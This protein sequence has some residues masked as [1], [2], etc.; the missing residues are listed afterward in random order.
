MSLKLLIANK[1]YSSWSVRP[2]LVLDH[3]Q[4][5]YELVRGRLKSAHVTNE[6]AT[7]F[8][9]DWSRAGKVPVLRD[10]DLTVWESL[11][12]IEYLADRFPAKQIWPADAG[13]RALARAVS[14][15]MHAGFTPLRGEMPMNVRRRYE[16]F[17]YSADAAADIA[18]VQQLWA[19]C[20]ARSGGPFLFGAFCAADAMFAPVIS[21]FRTYGIELDAVSAAYAD[22]VWSLPAIKAWLAD[23]A[24]E[25]TIIETYEF[26]P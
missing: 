22:A 17:R 14:A 5:P 26:N 18:R 1:N 21:R 12:I 24:A 3:F 2:M 25:Q 4:I 19:D 20:L 8:I 7:E 10:G 11:A 23:A 15:E 16:N 9:D 13:E 6:I